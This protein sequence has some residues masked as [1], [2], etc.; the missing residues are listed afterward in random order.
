MKNPKDH[1]LHTSGTNTL[2]E[3]NTDI[4]KLNPIYMN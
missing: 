1:E 3:Q 4:V 2:Y